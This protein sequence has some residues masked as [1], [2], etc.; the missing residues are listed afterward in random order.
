MADVD[1]GQLAN[2]LGS[3]L[4]IFFQQK[5]IQAGEAQEQ[6]RFEKQHQLFLQGRELDRQREARLATE[7][8]ARIA[9]QK[10]SRE[11][12]ERLMLVNL[13]AET[14]VE[15][16]MKLAE[17][18][19]A[20]P[21]MIASLSEI[22]GI[23][24]ASRAPRAPISSTAV[25]QALIQEGAS[26][27]QALAGAKDPST[28]DSDAFSARAQDPNKLDPLAFRLMIEGRLSPDE[29]KAIDGISDG[30]FDSLPVQ[31]QALLPGAL[32]KAEQPAGVDTK[33]IDQ[34]LNTQKKIAEL[35][36]SGRD[37]S[38]LGILKGKLETEILQL[39]GGMLTPEEQNV[40]RQTQAATAK[41]RETGEQRQRAQSRI[42]ELEP[43]SLFATE[44]AAARERLGQGKSLTLSDLGKA[45][46]GTPAASVGSSINK[47]LFDQS[48]LNVESG[49][50]VT[51]D[52]DTNLELFQKALDAGTL[53]P[54]GRGEGGKLLLR[55]RAEEKSRLLSPTRPERKSTFTDEQFPMI[56]QNTGKRMRFLPTDTDLS[57]RLALM[58]RLGLD[59]APP[60]VR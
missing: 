53:K 29:A 48:F 28:V 46:L 24:D 9:S 30:T 4:N 50:V 51:I 59:F 14:G 3:I 12:A 38:Q 26:V 36:L 27:E 7:S 58:K 41:E 25:F 6:E 13:A 16:A 17:F 23:Q 21:E 42:Q 60:G 52:S 40:F 35:E 49:Q 39:Q 10:E 5:R 31:I 2:S 44:A 34:I 33:R 57:E 18:M 56:S 20:S 47:L 8:Q 43:T 37:T 54:L 32:A 22:A 45:F 1:V 11:R 55:Q 19:G 15:S